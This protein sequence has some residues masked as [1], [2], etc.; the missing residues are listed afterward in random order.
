[1]SKIKFL[2]IFLL[3]VFLFSCQGKEDSEP[4]FLASSYPIYV[5]LAEIAGDAVKVDYI[6]PNGASPHTYL[7]RP[8]DS[9]KA[10]TALGLFYIAQNFD[11]WVADIPSKNTIK[12]I[13]MLSIDDV[14]YFDCGHDHSA[15]GDNQEHESVIDPHFW[16]DPITVKSVVD[17]LTNTMIELYPKGES[18]FRANSEIFKNNL[19]EIDLELK[20]ILKSLEGKDVFLNHPSF[21]YMLDR[22]GLNYAGSIEESPGKEPSPK[23]IANLVDK[24]RASKT[25][26]IFS[27]PQLNGKTVQVIAEEAGVLMYELNPIGN[28][29]SEKTYKQIL[30]NNAKILKE[31]LE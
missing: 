15:E 10:A 12:L 29:D 23:F 7:P 6:A 4:L 24:I 18:V 11:G 22:Y 17:E 2:A 14:I 27:E 21:N 5:I 13:D 1:M 19:D 20:D 8:S 31:A 25:K 28:N 30:I 3:L 9:K 26:A 16:L